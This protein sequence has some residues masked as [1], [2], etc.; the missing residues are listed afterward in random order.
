R[1]GLKL[2]DDLVLRLELLA[3]LLDFLV[4]LVRAAGGGRGL[5]AEPRRLEIRLERLDELGLRVEPLLER[6]GARERR[7]EL[8]LAGRA[9]LVA[10]DRLLGVVQL[11]LELID[12]LQQLLLVLL[13]AGLVGAQAVETRL[14]RRV[15]LHLG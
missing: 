12:A 4:L 8:F 3:Q 6:R 7:R 14:Q 9:A 13:G 11:A 15:R 10:L 5:L 1:I 2:R